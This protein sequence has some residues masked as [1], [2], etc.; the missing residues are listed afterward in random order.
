[1]NHYETPI[2]RVAFAIAAVGMTA[3]TFGV[4]VILPASMHPD[5][6]EHPTLA[7]STAITPASTGDVTAAASINAVVVRRQVSTAPCPSSKSND[8]PES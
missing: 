3:L 5:N 1:M 7:A 8:R 2:P 6:R 4:S